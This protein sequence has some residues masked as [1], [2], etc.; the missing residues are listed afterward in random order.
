MK[1]DHDHAIF[2][3]SHKEHCLSQ[4]S[5]ICVRTLQDMDGKSN[6]KNK[7]AVLAGSKGSGSWTAL[8]L[9][10]SNKWSTA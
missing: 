3:D 4:Y 2:L 5:C 9:G 6:V 1:V 10:A 8:C 7:K